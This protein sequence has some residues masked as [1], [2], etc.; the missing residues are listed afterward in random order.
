MVEIHKSNDHEAFGASIL[1]AQSKEELTAKL[2]EHYQDSDP[3]TMTIISG[4]IDDFETEL[5]DLSDEELT[6]EDETGAI[7]GEALVAY[8]DSMWI[9]LKELLGNGAIA[10]TVIDRLI[11]LEKQSRGLPIRDNE[12]G[13]RA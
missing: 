4:Y 9:E 11:V 10:H 8:Y 7:T 5:K 6:E 1:T 2:V 13:T 3:E 12:A